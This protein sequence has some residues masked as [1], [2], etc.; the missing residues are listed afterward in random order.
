MLKYRTKKKRCLIETTLINLPSNQVKA[1]LNI[2]EMRIK[3][4]KIDD[5]IKTLL[6]EATKRYLRRRMFTIGGY[7]CTFR[8]INT[9]QYGTVIQ[10]DITHTYFEDARSVQKTFAKHKKNLFVRRERFVV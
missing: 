1:K 3:G 2:S 5:I 10:S 9:L 4:K 7:E 6:P 8:K